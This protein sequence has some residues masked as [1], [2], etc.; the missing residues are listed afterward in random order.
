MAIPLALMLAAQ[1]IPTAINLGK[2]IVQGKQAKKLAETPRPEFSI[3]QGVIDAVNNAKYVASMR[4][5]PGQ[6]LMEG[7]IGQNLSR[8]IADLKNVASSPAELSTNIARM[9]SGS[10]NAI[11]DIGLAAGQNWLNNQAGLRQ[12]LGQLGQYQDKQWQINKFQPYQNNMAASAALRE[13]SFRNLSAAGQN[14]ASGISGYANM[15]Y[16]QD[17][18]DEMLGT[19]KGVNMNGIGGFQMGGNGFSEPRNASMQEALSSPIISNNNNP[20]MS[21]P[22]ASNIDMDAVM[23]YLQGTTNSQ[24]QGF[25]Q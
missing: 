5:L 16:Q 12:A 9:Y 15:K 22:S 18:L 7:R 21:S 24:Y 14:L 25:P 17:M 6:N 2:S 1:A 4:E 3:P 11:N 10:N 19:P 23:K 20:F 13:G 8:G